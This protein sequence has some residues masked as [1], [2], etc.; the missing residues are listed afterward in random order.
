MVIAVAFGVLICQL[1][2]TMIVP[3][4]LDAE[5]VYAG[6]V[7]NA[8]RLAVIEEMVHVLVFEE[9]PVLGASHVSVPPTV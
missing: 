2:E 3:V 8:P 4:P 6:D 7:V 1:S 5:V 9:K